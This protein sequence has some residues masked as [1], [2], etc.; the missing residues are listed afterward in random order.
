[1]ETREA[2]FHAPVPGFASCR[3]WR[4]IRVD[5]FGHPPYPDPLRR[6]RLR[7]GLTR[8]HPVLTERLSEVAEYRI[9]VI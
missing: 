4:L 7:R 1:M 6:D 3:T 2:I 9:D 5:G 8:P